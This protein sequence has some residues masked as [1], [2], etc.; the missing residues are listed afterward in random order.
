MNAKETI[1][2]TGGAGA[3]GSRLVAD[4]CRNHKVLV[5]DDLSSG[6]F[7][8]LRGLPVSFWRGSVT[9]EEILRE[10]FSEKPSVVFHLAAN[11]ANQN[12][13]DYPQKDLLVN[14]LGTLKVLE[15]S[16]QIGIKRFIYTSS[17]CVYGNIDL[18]IREDMV[19]YNL[20]TPYAISKLA[21][22]HYAEFFHKFHGLPTVVLR[23][24]NSYGPGEYPGKY[25]NVIP[26]FIYRALNDLPLVVTGTGNETRDYTFVENTVA[27]L[28]LAMVHPEAVGKVFNVGTGCETS[29]NVLIDG[30]REAIGANIKVEYQNPRDWDHITRRCADITRICQQLNYHPGVSLSEGLRMTVDWFRRNDIKEFKMYN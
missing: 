13:V 21:G 16:R 2:V 27:A 9:D 7:D 15:F 23:L 6:W 19:G 8:N 30:I 10:V 14:G 26:N 4:L 11:F 29:L 20:D 3:I 22:E 28:K 17:S 1:L 5:L 18:P 25:R 12:S 24:F